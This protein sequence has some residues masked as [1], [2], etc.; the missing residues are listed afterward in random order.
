MSDNEWEGEWEESKNEEDDWGGEWQESEEGMDEVGV[1]VGV[2]S[3]VDQNEPNK[4]DFL[5]KP[6]QE[7]EK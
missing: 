2:S 3:T 7:Q 4:E 1:G 5:R 6:F